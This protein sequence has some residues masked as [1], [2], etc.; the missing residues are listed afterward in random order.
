MLECGL[1]EGAGEDEWEQRSERELAGDGDDEGEVD[2]VARD[3]EAVG[4]DADESEGGGER[5]DEPLRQEGDGGRASTLAPGSL[6][7]CAR[8][9]NNS[10]Q[11]ASRRCPGL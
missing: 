10:S 2:V 9:R 1:P 8:V 5:A 3:A 4:G 6:R 7:R 11:T